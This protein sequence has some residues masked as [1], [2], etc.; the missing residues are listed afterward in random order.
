MSF[1][2]TP[3]MPGFA[4]ERKVPRQLDL[5]RICH[6]RCRQPLDFLRKGGDY[7]DAPAQ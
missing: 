1:P 3:G 6:G 4:D 5:S 2:D 7:G